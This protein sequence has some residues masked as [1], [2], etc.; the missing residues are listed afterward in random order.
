MFSLI[1]L[2]IVLTSLV[3]IILSC[4]VFTNAIEFL[5]NK[6]KLGNNATG[7]ILAVIGT[8]LPETI[9]PIVAIFG[10]SF[11]NIKIDTAQDIA[12]GAIIGSPFM[13]STLTLF[14]LGL[15]LF[16]KKREFL[17]LD[18]KVIV[19]D[20]KYF[21]LACAFAF[22][23]SVKFLV[24]YKLISVLF[25][26]SLYVIF[27]YRTII[28]SR[29]TCVECETQELYFS[30]LKLNQNF[31]LFLQLVLSLIF[32]IFSSHFF[33]DEI[34]YF[35]QLLNISPSI[36]AL[37]ITPFATELP[38]TINSIIWLNQ[39]KDDLALANVLGAIVFQATLLFSIGLLL[40][41]WV[42]VKILILNIFILFACAIFFLNMI[43]TKKKVT[44][45]SLLFCGVFY[46][47]Y[48]IFVLLK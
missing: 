26:I 45:G 17:N 37:I 48:I 3:M 36:L 19:R 12:L 42:F 1:H 27:V 21:L 2:T 16:T 9:V 8:G 40:T 35:S 32:L 7:S 15:T 25:L 34:N 13:L 38:E 5:G 11:S 10:A 14:L 20:Y 29:S 4:V 22:L 23:F 43:I 30:K 28:K 44:A 47:V 33:V 46:F 6:M 31:S 39:Q 24:N 41:N 18:Y